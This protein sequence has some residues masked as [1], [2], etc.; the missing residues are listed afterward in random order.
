MNARKS[1]RK[2][3]NKLIKDN[4]NTFRHINVHDVTKE[5]T[6]V[7][8][9]NIFIF[10][11]GKN[12]KAL[13]VLDRPTVHAFQQLCCKL[14]LHCRQFL[15]SVSLDLE[16]L[17]CRYNCIN[18]YSNTEIPDEIRRRIYSGNFC[19]YSSQKHRPVYFSEL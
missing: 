19:C 8:Q 9:I 17:T 7:T 15:L 4:I 1:E 5:N 12:Q 3:I 16:G 2:Q 10:W 11:F 13:F 6:T 14:Q 18:R